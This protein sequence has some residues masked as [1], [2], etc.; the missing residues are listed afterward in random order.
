MRDPKAKITACTAGT[1]ILD[2]VD[3]PVARAQRRVKS[4]RIGIKTGQ[5]G[6]TLFIAGGTCGQGALPGRKVMVS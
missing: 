1:E 3:N 5:V 6:Q 4:R 2:R